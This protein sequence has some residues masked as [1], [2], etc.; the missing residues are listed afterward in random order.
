MPFTA[1]TAPPRGQEHADREC[2]VSA[3]ASPAG[4]RIRRI[5]KGLGLVLGGKAGAGLIS[6][7]YLL[8]ATRYLGPADYG[9]LVLVHAYTTTVCGIIEFPSWQAI[10]RY[11]AE[12]DR[13][14]GTHRL[15]R[16]LRF[17][18]TVEL[19]GG[20]FAIASAMVLS[21]SGSRPRVWYAILSL[22]LKSCVKTVAQPRQPAHHLVF[23]GHHGDP[24]I[25]RARVRTRNLAAQI[26]AGQN[27]HPGLHPELQRRRLARLC[28]HMIGCLLACR[29]SGLLHVCSLRHRLHNIGGH[30]CR[31][32]R[33]RGLLFDHMIGCRLSG[34]FHPLHH[35]HHRREVQSF[36]FCCF[37]VVFQSTDDTFS[38]Q[39][40]QPF[41]GSRRDAYLSPL[42]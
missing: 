37:N 27:P 41:L 17:G 4:N 23:R 39:I 10:L 19:I 34:R 22:V 20:A 8:L 13:D 31:P 14:G 6:L 18:A 33:L 38:M 24:D 21:S 11:G 36:F 42:K 35:F 15:G 5:F 3:E 26:G 7:L 2:E 9:V 16:L 30:R 32:R 28:D 1:S 29:L 12:A 40:T 25:P